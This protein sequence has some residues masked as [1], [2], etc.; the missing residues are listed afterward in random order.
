MDAYGLPEYIRITV[1]T[2]EENQKCLEALSFALSLSGKK[3]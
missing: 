2:A 3:D 1:G